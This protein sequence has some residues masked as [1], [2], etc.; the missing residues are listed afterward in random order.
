[1]TSNLLLD[2]LAENPPTQGL[3]NRNTPTTHSG[4]NKV[5]RSI[6]VLAVITIVSLAAYLLLSMPGWKD[7]NDQLTY[8]ISRSNLRV[9]VT[10]QGTLES[11]ENT[12]IKCKVRGTNTIIWVIEGGKYVNPGDE[13]VR[14][15]TL[16]LDEAI[17]ERTKYA[18]L[19]RS[20][21]ERL[22]ANVIRAELAIDEYL[23]GRYLSEV[24]TLE[25]E[26][27]VA[28]S[29]LRANE[30][31]VAFTIKQV[32]RGFANRLE[33]EIQE[34]ALTQARQAVEMKLR[35]IQVLEDFTKKEELATLNGDLQAA[36]ARYAAEYE[37]SLADASRRDRAVEELKHCVVKANRSGLVIYPSA[38]QW[39]SAPDIE[40]GATVHKDQVMLLMPN[41]NKMQAKVGIHES[42]VDRLKLGLPAIVTL[43]NETL[44]AKVSS[45]A[46]VT[47][48]AGWWTG[49]VVKYDTIIELDKS[50]G[51]K[52]GMSAEVEIILAE[53]KDVLTIPVAAVVQ[54][55]SGD[56]CWVK[57]GGQIQKRVLEL[58]DSNNVF[59]V[60]QAG[61]REGEMVILNPLAHID[62][63]QAEALKPR[64]KDGAETDNALEEKSDQEKPAAKPAAS[65]PLATVN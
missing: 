7:E 2:N 64:K 65:S 29:T 42:V 50:D 59:I 35:E 28:Q 51:L 56:A 19:T 10:E 48:P 38:A 62:E 53:H 12:K 32:K 3:G 58:G 8:T 23:K 5:V 60:V 20:S 46:T 63:A 47:K 40:A 27:A 34:T 14:L 41:L 52:P 30:D 9:T 43:T 26:L 13:L 61:L 54:S 17:S 55:E 25:K 36:R 44:D 57:T 31:Q 24:V 37:R 6:V 4:K 11:S 21:S 39:K 45:I 33:L 49:N 16:A 22:K 18:H 15:D 1:M